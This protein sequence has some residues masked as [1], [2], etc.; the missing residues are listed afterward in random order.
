MKYQSANIKN[1]NQVKN[2]KME[3]KYRAFYLSLNVIKFLEGLPTRG[4]IRIIT[5]QLIRC[6]TSIGA[7]IVEAKAAASKI[8]FV[9]YFQI[10]L[11]SSNESKYWLALLR[12]LI[13]NNRQEI[14]VFILEAEEIS[15]IIG[16]S[17][18]TMKG[19]RV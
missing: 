14:E 6:I 18:L 12:E 9:N 13:P 8:E 19:K 2:S 1:Q 11:K 5:D 17:V 10:A 15:K 4:A 7:N 16:S 3:L